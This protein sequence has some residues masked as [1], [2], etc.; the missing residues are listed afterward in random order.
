MSTKLIKHFDYSEGGISLNLA[1]DVEKENHKDEVQSLIALLEQ[2]TKDI[3]E[4]QS[5]L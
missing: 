2:A 1:L 5:K 3:K 4:Y